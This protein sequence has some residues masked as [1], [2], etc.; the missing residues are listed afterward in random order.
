MDEHPDRVLD[1]DEKG[2][3]PFPIPL[4]CPIIKRRKPILRILEP[5]LHQSTRLPLSKPTFH[6]K[7]TPTRTT[8]RTGGIGTGREHEHEQEQEDE[9]EHE[10]GPVNGPGPGPG[11]GSGRTRSRGG[12]SANM[13]VIDA[14]EWMFGIEI[15]QINIGE[16]GR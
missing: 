9:H 16:N 4:S 12:V 13:R 15:N 5:N 1:I 8:A 11:P 6:T 2:W 7:S 3:F 10:S 14:L